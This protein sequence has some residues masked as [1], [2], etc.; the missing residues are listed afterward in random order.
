V[1]RRLWPILVA[2]ALAFALVAARADDVNKKQGRIRIGFS[3]ALFEEELNQN[4][5]RAAVRAWADSVAHA[6]NIEVES[7]QMLDSSELIR[8]IVNHAID[9]FAMTTPE[10]S[11]VTR[12]V[13]P[14]I[15]IDM[16]RG[17]EY[18]LLVKQDSGIHD[19]AG[20]RG[21]SLLDYR[22][23][24]MCMAP[25]WLETLLASSNLD[26]SDRFFG[27]IAKTSK[28]SQ[29]VLPVFFGKADACIITSRAFD[30]M[31]ELNPQLR[32]KLRILAVSPRLEAA[33]CGI[34]KDCPEDIKI[35]FREALIGM[36]NS[37]SGHQI[38]TLVQSDQLVTADSAILQPSLELLAAYERLKT[39][40]E[41][42]AR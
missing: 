21:R 11:K 37:P 10:Y 6:S 19:L 29:T 38:L 3:S 1:I 9:G 16:Q 28:V 35:R 13:D 14:V 7:P 8:A 17:V 15:F 2:A 42:R 12:L 20:L 40:R 34:H 5:A 26:Q 27:H 41:G 39:R 4:D 32:L 23:A 24:S 36:G 30:V 33:F 25:A 22:H 18:V 31:C